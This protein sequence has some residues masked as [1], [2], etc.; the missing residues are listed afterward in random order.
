MA[1]IFGDLNIWAIIGMAVT[2][3]GAAALRSFTGFGFSL[4]AVPVLSQ[5]LLPTTTVPIA[6]LLLLSVSL[7][8]LRS[9]ARE[10]PWRTMGSMIALSAVGTLIGIYV[11]VSIDPATF[12]LAIGLSVMAACVVLSRFHPKDRKPG[13][14]TAWG[15]G[16]SSGLLNGALAIP[17]PPVIVYAMAAFHKP[18]VSRAFLM[19]FFLFSSSFATLGYAAHGVID[20]HV[21]SLFGLALPMMLMGDKAGAVLFARY[22]GDSYRKIA[23]TALFAVGLSVSASALL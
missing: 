19:G 2:I 4:A 10:I 22:G 11:L 7:L 8:T 15:A 1:D 20:L 6:T 13:G 3:F 9:Y 23:I 14:P 16:L 18:A 17:G 12:K 5:F 21:L